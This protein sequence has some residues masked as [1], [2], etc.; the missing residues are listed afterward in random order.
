[1][2]AP[3]GGVG[4]I[5]PN[6]SIVDNK[7][8]DK[9]N[10]ILQKF[11]DTVDGPALVLMRVLVIVLV[12]VSTIVLVIVLVIV[13]LIVQAIVLMIVLAIVLCIF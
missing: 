1:M 6:T 13:L 11:P 12:I 4:V 10:P 3:I 9:I 7:D 2:H 8:M 5:Y